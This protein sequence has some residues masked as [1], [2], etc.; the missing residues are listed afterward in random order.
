MHVYSSKD[1]TNW[2]D[3]GLALKVSDDP[4]SDI[5]RACII[6]RPKV[7]Y[8]AKRNQFVMW[9]HLELKGQGY[10][11]ARSGIAYADKPSGPYSYIRS[12]RPHAGVWPQ[13]VTAE[14]KVPASIARTRAEQEQFSGGLTPKQYR[15]SREHLKTYKDEA[16]QLDQAA[17]QKQFF[18]V[19]II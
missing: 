15:F 17:N 14:Q 16:Y 7:I 8:N 12:I 4:S 19:I 2:K 10:K 5:V 13:N 9:F 11:A 6:E 18:Q 3:E 1:L